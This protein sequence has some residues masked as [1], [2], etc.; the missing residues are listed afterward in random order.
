MM[1]D[2][3]HPLDAQME[4]SAKL[5]FALYHVNNH[6]ADVLLLMKPPGRAEFD[7]YCRRYLRRI[8]EQ[9][10]AVKAEVERQRG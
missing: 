5:N 10:D 8:V 3:P 1:P 6:L 7:E 9:V 2:Q 4:V